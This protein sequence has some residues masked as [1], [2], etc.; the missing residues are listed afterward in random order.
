MLRTVL[1]FVA[2]GGWPFTSFVNR[3]RKSGKL[4]FDRTFGTRATLLD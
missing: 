4:W 3:D 1:G 2:I